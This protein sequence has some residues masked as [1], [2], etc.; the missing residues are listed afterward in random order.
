MSI[1]PY[2]DSH[3]FVGEVCRVKGQSVVECRLPGSEIGGILAISAKASPTECVCGD[4]EVKYA[5]RAVISIVYEDGNRKLCRAERGVEFFHK[6]EGEITPAC[7]AK[8]DYKTENISYRR[9]GSGLYISVIIGADIAVFGNRQIE[10]LVNGE[11]LV[12][13]KSALTLTKC[14]CVSGELSLEDEFDADYVGDILLQ[15]QTALVNHIAATAGQIEL[16]GEIALHICA[17]K[18]E[19]VCS[20]ERLLPFR[21]QVPCDEAFG[22]VK[23]EGRVR[24]KEGRLTASTDEETG[25]KMLFVGTLTADCFVYAKEEL[26]CVS[27]AFSTEK[28]IVLKREKEGGRYLTNTVRLVERVSG[29]PSLS[30]EI[31]GSLLSALLPRAEVSLRKS[32]R[33]MEAE[34]ALLAELLYKTEEGSVRAVQLTLPFLFPVGVEGEYGEAECLVSG[35]KVSRKKGSEVAIEAVVRMTASGYEESEWSYISNLEEG[36][37]YEKE[38]AALSVYLTEEGE[39]LWSLA[40]RLRCDTE[41]LQRN[42]PDLTFPLKKGTRIFVYR[43]I[44]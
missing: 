40:K 15:S 24:I 11:G 7:F 2:F 33:G 39:E 1:Q 8:P 37:G 13:Q 43:Q 42:N 6:A 27:D 10:R 28:E 44:E 26:D 25:S 30:E 4:G 5:G 29:T 19:G 20:Y 22:S 41:S 16:E 32:E 12:C 34:G 23:A 17:L 18:G 36:E 9:E 31:E 35:L 21:M 3:R 14:V 38:S